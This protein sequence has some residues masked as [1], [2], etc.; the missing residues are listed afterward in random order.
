MFGRKCE[1][2]EI[3][4]GRCSINDKVLREM[5]TLRAGCNKAQPKIFTP[6]QILFPGVQDGQNLISW[7]WSLPS[8]TDPV[9]W[10]SMHASSSYRGNTATNKHTQ[11]G[12]ITIHC[13]AK[14]SVQCNKVS[15]LVSRDWWWGGCPQRILEWLFWCNAVHCDAFSAVVEVDWLICPHDSTHIC[16]AFWISYFDWTP[17]LKCVMLSSVILANVKTWNSRSS[18]LCEL[19][20]CTGCI[21][22]LRFPLHNS[23]LHLYRHLHFSSNIIVWN[24]FCCVML[25]NFCRDGLLKAVLW[26]R[27]VA[28]HLIYNMFDDYVRWL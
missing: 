28:E 6:P 13:A 2:W 17:Q 16:C 5:Q 23:A 3:P 18:V 25:H 8:P 14:L 22:S 11:T 20:A 9:W 12:P 21:I 26:P 4:K 1:K 15:I 27:I 7:R 24:L 19:Y 10:R